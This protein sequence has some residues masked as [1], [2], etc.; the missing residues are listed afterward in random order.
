MITEYLYVIQVIWVTNGEI[1]EMVKC[2]YVGDIER[3]VML[4]RLELSEVYLPH[5]LGYQGKENS[6]NVISVAQIH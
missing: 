1:H 6:N 3:L 5:L 2:S 4:L